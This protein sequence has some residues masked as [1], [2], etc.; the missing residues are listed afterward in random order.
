MLPLESDR[1]DFRGAAGPDAP[2]ALQKSIWE[3]VK[4]SAKG[5]EAWQGASGIQAGRNGKTRDK[6]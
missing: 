1:G 6:M 4:I 5:V 3:G 2:V